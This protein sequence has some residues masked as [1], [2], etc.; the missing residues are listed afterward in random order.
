M[1]EGHGA[2]QA[3]ETGRGRFG[4]R[5]VSQDR[6][7][8]ARDKPNPRRGIGEPTSLNH[9]LE[10]RQGT[11]DNDLLH[12]LKLIDGQT[13]RCNI[14]SPEINNAAQV[15]FRLIRQLGDQRRKGVDEIAYTPPSLSARSIDRVIQVDEAACFATLAQHVGKR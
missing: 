5:I 2:A 1:F 11:S 14:K 6:D 8:V 15:E 9:G 7:G 12:Y 4:R 10:E 3:P 13:L